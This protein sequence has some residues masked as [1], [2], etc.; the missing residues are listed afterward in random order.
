[1]V[2]IP[3][4][5]LAICDLTQLFNRA[6][7]PYLIG[8][9]IASSI[10]G[11]FRTTNDIDCLCRVSKSGVER[12]LAGADNFIVDEISLA[13]N[14]LQGR[15]YNLIHEPTFVKIDLFPAT[16]PFHFEELRR[17]REVNPL[18]SPCTFR[19]A[20]AEDIILAKL[21]WAGRRE[22]RSERQWSD[23]IGILAVAGPSLDEAYLERWA[24]ELGV[25]DG[26]RELKAQ[27][28]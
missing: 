22:V 12:F 26:L 16:E 27:G 20:S 19:I 9:S 4:P 1:M 14:L 8:G 5:F 15:S 2:E 7:M 21:I 11:R 6:D 25:L 24:A 13:E 23:L 3:D 10:Y 18:S 17:A 28:G